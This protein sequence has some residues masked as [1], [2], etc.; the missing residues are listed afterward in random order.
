VATSIFVEPTFEQILTDEMR[1]YMQHK[2]NNEQPFK[3]FVLAL[4]PQTQKYPPTL[5]KDVSVTPQIMKL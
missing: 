1:T 3:P 2:A 5:W 4:H